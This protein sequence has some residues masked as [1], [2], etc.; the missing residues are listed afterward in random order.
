MAWMAAAGGMALAICAQVILSRQVGLGLALYAVALLPSALSL[1]FPDENPSVMRTGNAIP[2]VFTLVALPVGVWTEG[3][4]RAWQRRR[5]R[6][7][8][9]PLVAVLVA[10]LAWVNGQ[11]VFV[12]YLEGYL[13]ALGGAG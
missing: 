13:E 9:C 12:R 8:A 7:L 1:S 2:V 10:A 4:A 6:V 3:V 11:R 5:Q